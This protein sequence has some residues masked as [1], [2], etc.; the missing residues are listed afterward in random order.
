MGTAELIVFEYGFAEDGE[1]VLVLLRLMG[2]VNSNGG[3]QPQHAVWRL[4]KNKKLGSRRKTIR[5]N[6][7][8]G[9]TSFLP[10]F[11]SAIALVCGS[12]SSGPLLEE[13]SIV[14]STL[15]PIKGCQESF[16]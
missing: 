7:T 11:A 5:L 6:W 4:L 16:N 1:Y 14:E 13:V 3:G 12:S 2:L 9:R 10:A 15:V 8:F